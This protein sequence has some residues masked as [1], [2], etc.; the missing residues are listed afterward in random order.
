MLVYVAQLWNNTMI[1]KMIKS[2]SDTKLET[3]N[4]DEAG[5][6]GV[7]IV[8]DQVIS[9]GL[10]CVLRKMSTGALHVVSAVGL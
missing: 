8:A 5:C 7:L 10:G 2:W 3:H 1:P 4:T 6:V 9:L